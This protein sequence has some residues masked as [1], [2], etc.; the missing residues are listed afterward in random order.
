ML[1][2]PPRA[3]APQSSSLSFPPPRWA[4]NWGPSGT[5]ADGGRVYC[6]SSS[7][8]RDQTWHATGWSPG[9]RRRGGPLGTP[10]ACA[11]VR[12]GGRLWW[13]FGGWKRRDGKGSPNDGWGGVEE[14]PRMGGGAQEHPRKGGGVGGTAS[15]W[16]RRG[17]GDPAGRRACRSAGQLPGQPGLRGGGGRVNGP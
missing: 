13:G 14:P 4:V 2:G 1:P 3:A 5:A 10:S 8:R 9:R 7:R 12:R 17:R 16:R 15:G 6:H 11:R